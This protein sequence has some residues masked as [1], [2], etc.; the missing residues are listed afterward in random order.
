V[1]LKTTLHELTAAAAP[2]SIK[3]SS[4]KTPKALGKKVFCISFSFHLFYWWTIQI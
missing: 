1:Q 2:N 3:I 4:G